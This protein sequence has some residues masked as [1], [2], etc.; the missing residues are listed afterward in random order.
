MESK[1]IIYINH[2]LPKTKYSFFSLTE[3]KDSVGF[4]IQVH[5]GSTTSFLAVARDR[6]NVQ[7]MINEYMQFA[8]TS[9]K[10]N[11]EVYSYIQEMNTPHNNLLF[12][13]DTICL[14][15]D[16][17]NIKEFLKHNP[18]FHNKKVLIEYEYALTREAYQK[19]SEDFGQYKHFLYMVEGNEEGVTLE[20]Y[21]I[22]LSLIEEIANR[23]LQYHF[24]PFELYLYFFDLL[25]D[26]TYEEV[27]QNENPHH[28]RDL[29][30]VLLKKKI[31]C[32]GFANLYCAVCR[33]AH[34]SC[35][36]FLMQGEDIGHARNIAYIQ[37]AKYTLDGIYFFDLTFGSR[38]KDDS[39]LENYRFFAKTREEFLAYDEG[40]VDYSYPFFDF[41][42]LLNLLSDMENADS[43]LLPF[44]QRVGFSSY[45]YMLCLVDGKENVS[46]SPDKYNIIS[47]LERFVL[48]AHREISSS[49]F[50]K[51]LYEVRK[52]EYYENPSKYKFSL[53][54]L[55]RILE[56]SFIVKD[57]LD[58]KDLEEIERN[59][60]GVKLTK[61]LR[62]VLEKKKME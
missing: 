9:D 45:Y 17:E 8:I 40:L 2:D 43:Y 38:K 35:A 34:L 25:R 53:E 24:S 12:A 41:S 46:F 7:R 39:F 56:N 5:L 6:R 30:S 16:I 36:I 14:K 13:C 60:Q 26:R 32:F 59:I 33:Q 54:S 22:T 58:T 23:A 50:F 49:V 44:V 11:P 1:L 55:L 62:N 20:D 42:S 52:V 51:A 31:V 57:D 61:V 29:T 47:N 3:N 48:L 18:Y 4:Q 19:A 27:E 10:T 28:S 15:G 37:D 21:A